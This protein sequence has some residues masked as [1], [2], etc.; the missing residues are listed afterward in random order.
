M[1]LKPITA[2]VKSYVHF[3]LKTPLRS[4]DVPINKVTNLLSYIKNYDKTYDLNEYNC[5]DFGIGVF[6]AAG[7]SLPKTTGS[8]GVGSGRNPGDLGQDIRSLNNSNFQINKNGGTT[9]LNKGNCT[10]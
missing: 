9:P 1:T 8:W 2:S 3:A 5:T 10:N 4:Y 6:N 7:Y